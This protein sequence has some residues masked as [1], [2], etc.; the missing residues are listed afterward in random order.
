MGLNNVCEYLSCFII[1]T[2]GQDEWVIYYIAAWEFSL[3]FLG[4]YPPVYKI[5]M[6]KIPTL[7]FGGGGGGGGTGDGVF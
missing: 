1:P 4:K 2:V 5:S 6:E 7:A 3:I